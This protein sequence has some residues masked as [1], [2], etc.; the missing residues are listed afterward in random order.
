MDKIKLISIL[1]GSIFTRDIYAQMNNEDFAQMLKSEF[2]K[3]QK[4]NLTFLNSDLERPKGECVHVHQSYR[5]NIGKSFYTYLGTNVLTIKESSVRGSKYLE[6][7]LGPSDYRH[8][9]YRA[10]YAFLDD[11][12]DLVQ[13]LDSSV[14]SGD[15][16]N[17]VQESQ[18]RTYLRRGTAFNKPAYLYIAKTV[19][20]EFPDN[21][22]PISRSELICYFY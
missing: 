21:K 17:E 7:W 4:L 2:N 1:L 5:K 16:D 3:A 13:D 9:Y 20:F 6:Y 19:T 14:S 18:T 22:N 11:N 15:A 12:K 10:V 8:G